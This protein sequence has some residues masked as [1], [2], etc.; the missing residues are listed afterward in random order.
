MDKLTK[1]QRH[2]NMS[3]TLGKDTRRKYL[4]CRGLRYRKND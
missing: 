2:Y 1:E 3:R 4:F